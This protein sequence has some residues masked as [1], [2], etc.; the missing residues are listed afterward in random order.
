MKPSFIQ[1][2]KEQMHSAL[3]NK[4]QSTVMLKIFFLYLRKGWKHELDGLYYSTEE[5]TFPN[6]NS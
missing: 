2:I 1:G 3:R 4:T 6:L 5:E